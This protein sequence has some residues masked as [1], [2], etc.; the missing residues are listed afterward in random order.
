MQELH[1]Q[2][3]EKKLPTPKELT[4]ETPKEPIIKKI[5][6]VLAIIQNILLGA[7]PILG[8]Y[9]IGI[10]AISSRP[11]NFFVNDFFEQNIQGEIYTFLLAISLLISILFIIIG[12]ALS[13]LH[14]LL[15]K[16]DKN[17]KT[18]G[19]KFIMRGIV[20]FILDFIIYFVISLIIGLLFPDIPITPCCVLP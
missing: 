1:P 5:Y 16:T 8:L 10:Y 7:M 18:Y 11:R 20:G 2:L 14:L 6:R 15:N 3:Q 4:I 13:V 19:K 17:K 9:S 12:V